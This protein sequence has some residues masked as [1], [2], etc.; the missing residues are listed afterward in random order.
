MTRVLLVLAVSAATAF[1]SINFVPGGLANT[2]VDEGISPLSVGSFYLNGGSQGSGQLQEL[3]LASEFTP[4]GLLDISQFAF[5]DDE[6]NNPAA[7]AATL[8]NIQVYLSTS[9]QTI[10][11][12]SGTF[13]DNVTGPA[14]LVYSGPITFNIPFDNGSP[15]GFNYI[16]PFST[17][18]LYNPAAGNLLVDILVIQGNDPNT[19]TLPTLDYARGQSAAMA[20]ALDY[21]NYQDA[22]GAGAASSSGWP[23]QFTFDSVAVPEPDSAVLCVMG[24]AVLF[25]IRRSLK[26]EPARL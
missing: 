26:R 11:G 19:S 25:T 3:Y 14:T 20:V 24:V 5:R 16:I 10:G 21:S 2:P 22:S 1:G 7:Y 18:F 9:S 23:T 6:G 13:S 15:R 4:F 17:D 8:Q 12:M